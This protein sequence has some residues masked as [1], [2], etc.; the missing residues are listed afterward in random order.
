MRESPV[1]VGTSIPS[2]RKLKDHDEWM[3]ERSAE[4]EVLYRLR[5]EAETLI[6]LL[7]TLKQKAGKAAAA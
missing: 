2:D 6:N 1:S 3:A 7:E 4:L 5:V